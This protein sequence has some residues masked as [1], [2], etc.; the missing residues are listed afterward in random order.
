MLNIFRRVKCLIDVSELF[1]SDFGKGKPPTEFIVQ[2]LSC[3][4]L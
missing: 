3:F 2:L 1:R 4:L